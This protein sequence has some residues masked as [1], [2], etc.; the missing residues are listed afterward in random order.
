[1]AKRAITQPTP[2]AMTIR[3]VFRWRHGVA[4]SPTVSNGALLV[5]EG[6]CGLCDVRGRDAGGVEQLRRRSGL[7]ESGDGEMGEARVHPR[8]GEP[9]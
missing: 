9:R 4:A 1:M 7:G 3:R 5:E 8:L 6:A 2:S